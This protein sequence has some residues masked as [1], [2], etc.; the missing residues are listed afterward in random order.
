M[1]DF[2]NNY[3]DKFIAQAKGFDLYYVAKVPYLLPSGQAVADHRLGIKLNSTGALMWELL[4][5][6]ESF[7]ELLEMLA[8]KVPQVSVEQLERDLWMFLNSIEAYGMLEARE[9]PEGRAAE[10]SAK[11]SGIIEDSSAPDEPS[12]LANTDRSDGPVTYLK[13]GE[14]IIE[15]TGEVPLLREAFEGFVRDYGAESGSE[16][17]DLQVDVYQVEDNDVDFYESC[18]RI[19]A[20]SLI[21]PSDTKLVISAPDVIIRHGSGHYYITLPQAK[22]LAG[23]VLSETGDRASF[24]FERESGCESALTLRKEL[25]P[26]DT[27]TTA[28]VFY[29]GL[30]LVYLYHASMRGLFAIHSASI[31]YEG[32]A[33]LFSGVSG[34]GKSTH[35]NL[36]QRLYGTPVLNGDLNL[37]DFEDDEPTVHGLPW[38]GTSGISTSASFPLGGIVLLQQDGCDYVE[39]LA[40]DA[41]ALLSAQRFI[42]PSWDREQLAAQL[43]FAEALSAKVPICRLHCTKEESAAVTMKAWI[44]AQTQTRSQE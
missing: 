43:T 9:K 12:S 21:P 26:C 13:I 41:K 32:K 24:Y 38:C 5:E 23:I 7:G 37:L 40:A 20:Y 31:L 27:L 2:K 22:S 11:G 8:S 33:W 29:H 42:S 18:D 16:S 4:G 6:C 10:E 30:R 39:E 34:T 19:L 17:V 35:T 25:A 44:D 3:H 36:W 1:Q 15:I 28:E 14:S